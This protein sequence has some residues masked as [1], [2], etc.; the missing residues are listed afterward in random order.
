MSD[1]LLERLAKT[2]C[3]AYLNAQN[4]PYDKATWL[5]VIDAIL[6]EIHAQGKV[7]VPRELPPELSG[8]PSRV[9]IWNEVMDMLK[10]TEEKP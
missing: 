5:N 3:H 7:I 10:A 9:I 8:S 6:A 1:E 4:A 2:A